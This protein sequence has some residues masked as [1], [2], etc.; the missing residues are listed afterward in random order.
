M[1]FS[2]LSLAIRPGRWRSYPASTHPECGQTLCRDL[3]KEFPTRTQSR[4][5]EEVVVVVVVVVFLVGVGSAN[6]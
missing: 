4:G 6:G 1:E 3:C 2:P 5:R